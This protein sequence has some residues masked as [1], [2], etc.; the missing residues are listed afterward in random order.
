MKFIKTFQKVYSFKIDSVKYSPDFVIFTDAYKGNPLIG[1]ETY[2]GTNNLSEG[3]H[4][5]VYSK[6]NTILVL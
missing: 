6:Y 2:I 1:L 5:L 4:T 3:K